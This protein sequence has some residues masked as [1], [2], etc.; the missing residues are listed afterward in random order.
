MQITSRQTQLKIDPE[1]DREMII[2][3]VALL[4][5]CVLIGLF[6]GQVLGSVLGIQAN[7]GGVGIAICLLVF[8][9]SHPASKPHFQGPSAQGVLFWSGMYIPIIVAMA[10]RQDVYGALGSG[11]IAVLAGMS[12]VVISFAAIPILM[13]F[14]SRDRAPASISSERR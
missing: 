7:V 1:V 11:F 8:A 3:G 13:L 12:A 10:A 9:C 14:G 2:Y 5:L 4:S 6:L